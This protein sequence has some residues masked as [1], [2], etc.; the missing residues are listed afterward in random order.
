MGGI[1][2]FFAKS[3]VQ[4]A[5]RGAMTGFQTGSSIAHAQYNAAAMRMQADSLRQQSAIQ[6]YMIRKN[7]ET[8]Y[9]QLL[10]KQAME[11][12][13]NRVVAMKRGITGASA[14]AVLGAYAA[15]GQKNLDQL[16]Y[17]AAMQT[18]QSSLKHS[19]QINA[20]EEK[21]RQYDWQASSAL[22]GGLINLGTGFFDQ[23]ISEKADGKVDP[24]KQFD[25]EKP[26]WNAV[27]DEHVEIAQ[28][29]GRSVFMAGPSL[30]IRG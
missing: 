25:N 23:A 18:A 19:S 30:G 1:G 29:G 21:A 16:Y 7:Y 2:D 3:S 9:Q 22:I 6:A 10:D 13:M 27:A 20:L 24:T 8:E 14:A 15:K 17:N 4:A 11:Q 28:S 12:S 5:G 26:D